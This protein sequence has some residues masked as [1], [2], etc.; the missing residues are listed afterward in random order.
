[1]KNNYEAVIQ[2]M[3]TKN[4]FSCQMTC[5]CCGST[6]TFQKRTK[7]NGSL[8]GYTWRCRDSQCGT[9]KTVHSGSFF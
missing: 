8:D 4:L 5:S 9:M 2:Y 1:M 7:R 6:M 3:Q